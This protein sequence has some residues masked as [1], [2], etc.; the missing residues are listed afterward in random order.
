MI[1][2][3]FIL[4]YRICIGYPY[5]HDAHPTHVRYFIRVFD[6]FEYP[7]KYRILDG[8]VKNTCKIGNRAILQWDDS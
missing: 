3:Y 7:E 8:Y 4:S 1:H 5:S 2:K 6:I